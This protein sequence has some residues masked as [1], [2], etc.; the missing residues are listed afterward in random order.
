[1][2]PSRKRL[3]IRR[4]SVISRVYVWSVLLCT[5]LNASF[6][7]F[8]VTL[9][10]VIA[11]MSLYSLTFLTTFVSELFFVF[12]S[13][14]LLNAAVCWCYF[15]QFCVRQIWFAALFELFTSKWLT[16]M[17]FLCMTYLWRFPLVVGSNIILTFLKSNIFGHYIRTLHYFC[18]EHEQFPFSRI[19]PFAVHFYAVS[20]QGEERELRLPLFVIAKQI[21]II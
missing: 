18:I 13:K 8:F 9:K 11:F 12:S 19:S 1:M 6:F 16:S 17:L 3:L 4:I 15:L 7:A 5:P 20:V 2:Y 10:G 14:S 21:G